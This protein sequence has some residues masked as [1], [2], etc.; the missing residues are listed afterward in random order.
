LT[1]SLAKERQWLISRDSAALPG[2]VRELVAAQRGHVQ[3][4]VAEHVE[5]LVEALV[6]VALVGERAHEDTPLLEDL[7]L[8]VVTDSVDVRAVFLREIQLLE[9]GVELDERGADPRVECVDVLAHRPRANL[10]APRAGEPPGLDRAL[11]LH[12]DEP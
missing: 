2:R 7:R 5:R 4:E 12:V 3:A 10:P 8:Q 6:R 11:A 1:P 9:G